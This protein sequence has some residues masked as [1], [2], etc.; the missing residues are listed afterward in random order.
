MPIG[1]KGPTLLHADQTRHTLQPLQVVRNFPLPCLLSGS[2][3]PGYKGR[4]GGNLGVV[5]S[6]C[7]ITV[8]AILHVRLDMLLI[9]G[10]EASELESIAPRIPGDD[11]GTDEEVRGE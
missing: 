6:L 2:Q 4:S 7:I 5:F 10:L 1:R 3:N 9:G 11:S 8:L